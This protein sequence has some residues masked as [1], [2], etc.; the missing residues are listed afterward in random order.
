MIASGD[1]TDAN[2]QVYKATQSLSRENPDLLAT[3]AVKILASASSQKHRAAFIEEAEVML[4][5]KHKNLTQLVG[6]AIQ[7]R[8]WLSVIEFCRYGDLGS[9]AIFVP[10]LGRF[11]DLR[12]EPV[13]DDA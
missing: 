4:K 11:L 8:P 10:K 12:V 9:V 2:P 6:V 7:Q 1:A 5:L 13:A 3:R